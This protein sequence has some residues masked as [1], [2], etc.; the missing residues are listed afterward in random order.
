MPYKIIPVSKR[1]VKVVNAITGR[2]LA[3]STTPT[4]AKKQIKAIGM[5]RHSK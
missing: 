1:R 2:V 5:H 3:K 4:K